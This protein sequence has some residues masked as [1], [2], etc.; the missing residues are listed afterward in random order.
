[1]QWGFCTDK[2]ALLIITVET[3]DII[4]ETFFQ[5]RT[6]SSKNMPNPVVTTDEMS[7]SES[8][9][10]A[11]GTVTTRDIALL[12]RSQVRE[13]IVAEFLAACHGDEQK[14]SVIR[15]LV[16]EVLRN[17]T[18]DPSPSARRASVDAVASQDED[19]VSSRG[20]SDDESDEDSSQGSNNLK[21]A[22]VDSMEAIE[23]SPYEIGASAEV[24]E[25]L[26]ASFQKLLKP[27]EENDY[28]RRRKE[29]IEPSQEAV[30]IFG[31]ENAEMLVTANHHILQSGQLYSSRWLLDRR[32]RGVEL[33]GLNRLM[34]L[35]CLQE[36]RLARAGN[37]VLPS[38]MA[39][40]GI[41]DIIRE[42]LED[43]VGE[44][45][46]QLFPKLSDCLDTPFPYQS[47][48]RKACQKC[49]IFV[50]RVYT[51]MN[52]LKLDTIEN[53]R[54]VRKIFQCLHNMEKGLEYEVSESLQPPSYI[55]VSPATVARPSS[56]DESSTADN[57]CTSSPSK[58]DTVSGIKSLNPVEQLDP[59]TGKALARY[60]SIVD[61]NIGIGKDTGATG[62]YGV[63]KGDR[64]TAFGFKWRYARPNKPNESSTEEKKSPSRATK[65]VSDQTP[66]EKV[67]M[68]T[69]AVVGTYNSVS[70]A[71]LSVGKPIESTS[72][73]HALRGT[74]KSAYGFC[75]RQ[76]DFK[77][78]PSGAIASASRP[79]QQS[80]NHAKHSVSQSNTP[81]S[82]SNDTALPDGEKNYILSQPVEQLSLEDGKVVRSF[83]SVREANLFLQKDA[84]NWGIPDTLAGRQKSSSGSFWRRT[85][86]KTLPV[87]LKRPLEQSNDKLTPSLGSD[88]CSPKKSRKEDVTRTGNE[89]SGESLNSK[90][91]R[92]VQLDPETGK[93]VAEY[94]SEAEVNLSLGRDKSC[95]NIRKALNGQYKS[96]GGYLW[97][98]ARANNN[99]TH[100]EVTQGKRSV[101]SDELVKGADF[102]NLR[103]GPGARPIER[104]DLSTGTVLES[105]QAIK[106]AAQAM[107]INRK[108]IRKVLSGEARHA[109]GYFFREAG[110]SRQPPLLAAAAPSATTTATTPSIKVSPFCLDK[111]DNY[112]LKNSRMNQSNE[113]PSTNDSYQNTGVT[114]AVQ[115]SSYAGNPSTCMISE[116]DEIEESPYQE[117]A[118]AEVGEKLFE[119]FKELLI[120]DNSAGRRQAHA[121]QKAIQVFG[122]DAARANAIVDANTK[123]AF[124]GM[125]YTDVWTREKTINGFSLANIN[126]NLLLLLLQ[127]QRL[128]QRG[129]LDILTKIVVDFA[130]C[131]K[132]IRALVTWRL[133]GKYPKLIGATKHTAFG[134]Q[135]PQCFKCL[136]FIAR[137]LFCMEIMGIKTLPVS[138]QRK[139]EACFGIL[140]RNYGPPNAQCSDSRTP[141]IQ[142]PT[143]MEED[144][145]SVVAG[146][147]PSS[148]T[149]QISETSHVL[150]QVQQPPSKHADLSGSV[151]SNSPRV[152][153]H[154]KTNIKLIH[155]GPSAA[156][157]NHTSW[158]PSDLEEVI[159]TTL[160][161]EV[162][163]LVEECRYCLRNREVNWRFMWKYASPALQVELRR[164]EAGKESLKSLIR[165]EESIVNERF[166]TLCK[167]I[168]RK[169][170]KDNYR[171]PK[172]EQA[173][174]KEREASFEAV[175]KRSVATAVA[176]SAQSS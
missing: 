109:G 75:W 57:T 163:W 155:D 4:F 17:S 27:G 18:R 166:K 36:Q 11:N 52:Y 89:Q 56:G 66:I 112:P 148:T 117:G 44:E 7:T 136:V 162:A 170:L 129:T 151:I 130:L 33:K 29:T 110:S 42:V 62:I 150:F 43:L 175:A 37:D 133:A 50:A 144:E 73:Y 54:M 28:A 161:C 128:G 88:Q 68:T 111:Q 174:L 152:P 23:D 159:L 77:K 3:F 116:I 63:L 132:M 118:T 72:I 76:V 21:W 32:I 95:G 106:H 1:M 113:I 139:V 165:L 41:A 141:D 70:D 8:M 86:S 135:R 168:R 78:A 97:R 123:I 39:D 5:N 64:H 107:G 90:A 45:A 122:G 131:K 69:G 74:T 47:S 126:D 22:Q 59:E 158:V 119:D 84:R 164:M 81:P 82:R 171:R 51:C 147:D 167:D 157:Q 83:D 146:F 160:E 79:N 80:I 35:V 53:E 20:S 13:Q 154:P 127:E 58:R 98:Y 24:G 172:M 10:T 19:S 49:E 134:S 102:S 121:S 9:T 149:K 31:Y 108:Q 105:Y 48:H 46:T 173:I 137:T 124:S 93:I 99:P 71:N 100:Q 169:L 120:P 91:D 2:P 103:L 143:P 14:L 15:E 92:I 176:P 85:G 156:S 12:I 38:L 34:I 40:L 104:L 145:R 26:F 16:P 60:D 55:R 140:D 61:A 138:I 30:R 101:A 142:H 115:F 94:S 67:D 87:G 25:K 114:T 125:L 65:V 6:C 153:S 96:T